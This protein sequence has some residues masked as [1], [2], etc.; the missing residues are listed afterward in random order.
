VL[1][2]RALVIPLVVGA[3][4]SGAGFSLPALE[5]FRWE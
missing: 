3:V 1:V 2:L 4:A 5:S